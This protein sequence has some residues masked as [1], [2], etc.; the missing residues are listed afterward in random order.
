MLL[1]CALVDVV[2]LDSS[3]TEDEEYVK[4]KS[5]NEMRGA[6]AG[7]KRRKVFPNTEH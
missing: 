2:S 4:M 6:D 1:N 5:L 7:K 3:C